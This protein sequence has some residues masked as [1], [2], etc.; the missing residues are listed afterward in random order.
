VNPSAFA[1]GARR[2]MMMACV[3]DE[4]ALGLL[5]QSALISAD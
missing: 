5:P 1:G 2:S 4:L 3:P